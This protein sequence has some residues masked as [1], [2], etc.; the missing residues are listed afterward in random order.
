MQRKITVIGGD[1]RIS[2][3]AEM[4]LEDKNLVTIYG[5]ENCKKVMDNKSIAKSKSLKDAIEASD[6]IIGSIPFLKGEEEMYAT[7]SNKNIFIDELM[8]NKYKDKTF[9]AGNIP[10]NIK[11]ELEKSYGKVIDVMKREE[12]VILNT[13]AT[14]EGTIEVAIKNTDRILHGSK[15]LILGFGR[16]AKVEA[17][18]FSALATEVTCAARKKTDIAWIKALGY[19]AIDINYMN[20]YLNE[21]D[22][23]INTVPKMIVDKKS[24]K[25]MKKDV[26]MIDLASNPGGINREDA[27]EMNLKLIWA[28]ALPGKV[29]PVTSAQFIKESIY[30]ALLED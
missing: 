25:Y 18:K 14:T 22:I 10:E 4:F 23:I 24:M 6:I 7:F 28:L 13:I 19:D 9:I 3:L 29:A 26:L 12:L 30:N 1:L 11:K 17:E 21:F 20:E 2:T 5:M 27:K 8:K 15:V 16:V